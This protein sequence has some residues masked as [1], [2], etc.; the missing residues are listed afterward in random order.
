VTALDIPVFDLYPRQGMA[1]IGDNGSGKFT[2]IKALAGAIPP[3]TAE[4]TLAGE[5]VQFFSPG[6]A[7]DIGIESAHQ[8]PQVH[9]PRD[10]PGRGCGRRVQASRQTR[11]AASGPHETL[12]EPGFVTNQS[13]DQTVETL[14]K[15]CRAGSVRAWRWHSGQCRYRDLRGRRQVSAAAQGHWP[16][17]RDATG[18]SVLLR[19]GCAT[20]GLRLMARWT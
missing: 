6:A 18:A 14:S 19:T 10:P 8:T 20:L 17:R 5:L 11:N 4:I 1:V 15:P 13:V 3:D 16:A 12:R 7:R 9:G 2:M